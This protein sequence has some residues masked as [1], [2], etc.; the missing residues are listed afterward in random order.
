MVVDSAMIPLTPLLA[1][2]KDSFFLFTFRH[3]DRMRM[4]KSKHLASIL[5][6]EL[7]YL[8][9]IACIIT[10]KE[11]QELE[12][13][14]LKEWALTLDD[15][16]DLEHMKI[17]F[18]HKMQELNLRA[19]EP[20]NYS[21]TFTTIWNVIHFLALFTDDMILNRQ[22]LQYEFIVNHLRQLKAIYYNLFFKLDCAMCRDHYLNVK[23]FLIAAIE[24]IEIWL[25][26]ERF[27]EEVKMVDAVLTADAAPNVLMKYGTLYT[28][29]V[30]HNHINEYR[31]IQRNMKP[32][33]NSQRMHWDE[34]KKLLKLQ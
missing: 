4:L 23:G 18:H 25:N 2:Y 30:F 27:G 28:S 3:L 9:N 33:S 17:V 14:Q 5:A 26:R 34:Y 20:K 13:E 6:T 19:F 31:W 7:T 1:E 22:N 29:M 16:F 21:Y 15:K 10:Y 32:P 24:R 12:V 8:Y 11:I